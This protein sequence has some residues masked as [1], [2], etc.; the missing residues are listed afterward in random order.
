MIILFS[1]STEM[2]AYLI[3]IAIMKGIS[4]KGHFDQ[5]QLTLICYWQMQLVNSKEL[6]FD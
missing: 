2:R 4:C 3:K 1:K 6:I 5:L